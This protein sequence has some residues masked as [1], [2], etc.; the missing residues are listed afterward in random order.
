MKNSWGAKIYRTFTSIMPVAKNRMGEC[1]KCGVCC[2]LPNKC[3]FLM[4][5]ANGDAACTIYYVRPLNCRKYP[6]TKK[7]HITQ[8]TCGYKF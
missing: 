4:I 6:R 5:D 8:E 3:S 1:R 7:E 2:K